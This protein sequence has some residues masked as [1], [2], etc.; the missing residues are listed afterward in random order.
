M[1]TSKCNK[2]IIHKYNWIKLKLIILNPHN[3]NWIKMNKLLTN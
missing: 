1:K 3:I 2:K